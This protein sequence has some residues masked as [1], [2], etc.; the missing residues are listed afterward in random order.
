MLYVRD[1]CCTAHGGIVGTI[2]ERKRKD[3]STGYH[4][5]VVV[6]QGGVTH[7]ET[8]TFDRRGAATAWISKR[9]RELSAPGAVSGKKAEDPT[10]GAAIDRYVAESRRALG[11]TKAQVLKTIKTFDI[12]D[13]PC[14]SITS[15]DVV[16]FAKEISAGRQPQTVANYLA[17]L[18]S[19]FSIAQAAWGYQLDPSSMQD[20][21]KVTAKLG[22]VAKSKM[23]SR[24]PS[25]DELDR[26][27]KHFGGVRHRRPGSVPMQAIVAFALF[28]TRRQ[29]EITRIAWSDLDEEGSRV[30]VRDMKNP[31][32]KIGND[33][34]C[35]LPPEALLIIQAQPR[36]D[37]RIF[38]YTTDAIS[39][40]FTRACAFLGIDGLTFH[41][42]RHE[43]VSRLFEMGRTVPL[44]ASVSGHKSW[45]SLQ[46]YTHIRK[47]G[48]RYAGWPWLAVVTAADQP[49]S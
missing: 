9:E 19:V 10:L 32:Q 12:A 20:A 16:A 5:Q 40:A 15:A 27:M 42:L 30:L 25:L 1:P 26:L 41:D 3:G 38:P 4:A 8:K 49:Q 37:A 24:R 44:A 39:A 14:S 11:R 23:R 47:A 22:L 48:D 33:V 6:K 34:W 35:E 21:R 43:G 29:E 13:K 36:A 2:V 18:G 7:R 17:H 28:S 31:G 46:R 45:S